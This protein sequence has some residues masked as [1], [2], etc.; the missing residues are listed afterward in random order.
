MLQ[1]ENKQLQKI[2]DAILGLIALAFF[3]LIFFKFK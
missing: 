3:L 1:P 2:F